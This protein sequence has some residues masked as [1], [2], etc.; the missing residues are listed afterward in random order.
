[1][2]N[3]NSYAKLTANTGVANITTASSDLDGTGASIV[4]TAGGLGSKLIS[5]IVK[6]TAQTSANIVRLFTGNA[7]TKVL[8]DE[9]SIPAYP[10]L[11]AVPSPAPVLPMYVF[12]KIYNLDLS[13]G[14]SLFASSQN[15][16]SFNVIAEA[17]DITY[18]D[19]LPDVCCNFQQETP[20]SGMGIISIANPLLNGNGPM[21]DVFT[22]TNNYSGATIKSI[23]ISALQS[24]AA[25]MV[26]LF[27]DTG[28]GKF[29]M[30]E[31]YIPETTQSSSQSGF[32]IT[33]N[34]NYNLKTGYSISAATQN[35]QSF[36]I[37][38]SG[39]KWLY[40]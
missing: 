6:A 16:G 34:Q 8:I 29:L 37:S 5:V 31:I 9:I 35:G 18:P 7:G 26:R 25:G 28:G 2:S 14:I 17:L 22:S 38:V 30:N 33:L 21:T 20:V 11:F 12:Y 40:P 36:A 10:T 19:P 39:V 3:C 24:T 27:L 1:M 13:S 4:I 32:K 23:T 15:G